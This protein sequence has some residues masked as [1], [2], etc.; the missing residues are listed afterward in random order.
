MVILEKEDVKLLTTLLEYAEGA[1]FR[2]IVSK[3][4]SNKDRIRERLAFLT[5]N[6]LV[7]LEPGWT[8]GRAKRHFITEKGR[9]TLLQNDVDRLREIF[10]RINVL[11]LGLAS[12]PEM[13]R[14]WGMRG[15]KAVHNAARRAFVHLDKGTESRGTTLESSL[16]R[17]TRIRETHFDPFR[18]ALRDMQ[19]MSPYLAKPEIRDSLLGQELF[20]HV[21]EGLAI[22]AVLEAELDLGLD[23]KP[24]KPDITPKTF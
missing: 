5:K 16:Q 22:E 2:Q 17:A 7:S 3:M 14:T 12:K 4:R 13:L 19:Q 6:G 18:K 24:R 11:T 23:G 10:D 20:V 9:L 1:K 15:R 8:H 21:T